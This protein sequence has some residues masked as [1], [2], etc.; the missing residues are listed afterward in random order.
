MPIANLYWDGEEIQE[1]PPQPSPNHYWSDGDR[2]WIEPEPI[3]AIEPSPQPDWIGLMA[4][5]SGSLYFQ[6]AYQASKLTAG[7]NAAATLLLVV[8]SQSH[9]LEVLAFVLPDLLSEIEAIA[10]QGYIPA[11]HLRRKTG[12]R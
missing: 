3:D 1:K 11:F 6:R 10:A 8:V 9:N 12:T 4:W 7:A 2:A 5:L